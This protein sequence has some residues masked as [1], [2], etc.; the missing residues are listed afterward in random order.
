MTPLVSLTTALC[1]LSLACFAALFAGAVNAAAEDCDTPSRLAEGLADTNCDLLADAPAQA[2]DLRNP[3]TLVWAYTPIEDPTIYAELF[4]PFTRHLADCVGRQIVYY[5]V[6]SEEA[7]VQ[8]F[9]NGL[10]HFAGFA[11]GATVTAVERAGAQPFAAKGTVDGI[12]GYRLIAIV[13]TSSAYQSL[14]DLAGARVAHTTGQSNSG[15]HAPRRF[16]PDE[17]LLPG[18]DY[19][20]ILSGGH[21]QSIFGLLNGD[22]DM[23]AVASDVFERMAERG[24]INRLDFRVLYES[25]L[26]PTSSFALAHDLAPDLAQQLKNCFF[27]FD[28][29]ERMS[30]EFHG[31]N[32]FV[33]VRYKSDWQAVRD[34]LSQDRA[35]LN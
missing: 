26:F 31:D 34:V 2:A 18:T 27:N 3:K 14:R 28:F 30:K 6:Q 11:T 19:Q 33:P 7:Q 15:N 22:Y 23:S 5:P 16:F 13:R 9:A 35:T 29:P 4:R 1:N 8:A 10:L 32:R 25:P 12:R 17:G 24:R 21:A 20:P